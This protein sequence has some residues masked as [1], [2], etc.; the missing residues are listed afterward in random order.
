ML[1]PKETGEL[2]G[3]QMTDAMSGMPPPSKRPIALDKQSS[4]CYSAISK[5][6]GPLSQDMLSFG[7]SF[8][9]AP[10]AV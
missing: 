2:E 7:G 5:P 1:F 6:A 9:F 3:E 10:R 4:S 8:I